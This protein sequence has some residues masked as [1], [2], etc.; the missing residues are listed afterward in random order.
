RI[1]EEQARS[2]RLVRVDALQ[3][4]GSAGIDVGHAAMVKPQ[5]VFDVEESETLTQLGDVQFFRAERRPARAG[6]QP[7]RADDEVVA[8][9]RSI[10]EGHV[11]P[12][13]VVGE[14]RNTN[15]EAVMD[16]VADGFV[17]D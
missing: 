14:G 5:T 13:A 17:Q 1:A 7:I 9:R 4:R 10:A 8:S 12:L 16:V 3:S 11:D 15:A 2:G 6:V